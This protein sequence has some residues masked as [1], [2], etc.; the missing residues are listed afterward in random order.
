MSQRSRKSVSGQAPGEPAHFVPLHVIREKHGGRLANYMSR[1]KARDVVVTMPVDMEVGTGGRQ[2]FFVAV[3]VTSGFD[4][5][6]S[7]A[8]EVQ[9]MA[10]KRHMPL[11]A[12][13]PANLYGTDDFGIFIDEA[14]IGENLINGMVAEIIDQADIE[15]AVVAHGSRP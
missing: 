1:H 10:P 9:R 15:A 7:L 11:F 14:P 8:D 12:W 4:E 5:S 13:V 3:A 2:K 6:E